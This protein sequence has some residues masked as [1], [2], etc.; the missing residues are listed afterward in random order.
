[1]KTVKI[2]VSSPG[3]VRQ[4]RQV[5]AKVLARLETQF[6]RRVGVKGYFWEHEPM[7]AGA[8]FQTQIPPPAKFDVFIGIL[9]SRLGTRLH[10]SHLRPDGRPYL[11]GSE[12]EFETA[13]ESYRTSATK[14][15][16]LLIYRREETPLIPAE[17]QEV[18]EER[19]RQWDSLQR[20]IEHWFTDLTDGGTFKAAFRRYHNTAE[21]EELLE[22]HLR[23]TM[24][25]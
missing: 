24:L 10:S 23:K 8:D 2:F 3:D 4:E 6:A 1:M 20:F 19:K 25:V 12:F 21:F 13:L 5:T 7:H 11:S 14:T 18:F 9:W 16:R 15:P 17:P 22:E